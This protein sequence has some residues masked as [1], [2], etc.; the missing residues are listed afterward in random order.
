[1]SPGGTWL[2][3]T[4]HSPDPPEP[5]SLATFERAES[6]HKF[7]RGLELLAIL[8]Y[9]Y[10]MLEGPSVHEGCSNAIFAFANKGTLDTN[11]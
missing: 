7:Q 2:T 1:M 11:E 10:I 4:Q 9:S 5:A 6:Q 3:D 8:Y